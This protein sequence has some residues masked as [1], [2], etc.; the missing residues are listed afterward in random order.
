MKILI[1][2][3]V[4]K[5]PLIIN[6]VFILLRC[7]LMSESLSQKRFSEADE[8]R[9]ISYKILSGFCVIHAV[10]HFQEQVS[11]ASELCGQDSTFNILY[12]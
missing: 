10:W 7:I 9:E 4:F 12:R 5:K 8:V 3:L 2:L 6:V 11:E 1:N